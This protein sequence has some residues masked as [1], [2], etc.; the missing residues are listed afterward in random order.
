MSGDKKRTSISLDRDVYEFL[1]SADINQSGLINEL[2]KEYRDSDDRQL[3]ALELRYEHTLAEA[4][5]LQERADRK[6]D[7]AEEIKTLLESQREAAEDSLQ[8]AIEGVRQ[9]K[10]NQRSADNPAV[11]K[12]ANHAD[13]DPDTLLQYV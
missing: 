10:P 12:W 3:A 13:T 1:K 2:V 7:E 5:D 8:E 6:F 9:I 4:E 11:E